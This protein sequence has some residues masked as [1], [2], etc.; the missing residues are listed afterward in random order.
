[1]YI[2]QKK[3]TIQDIFETQLLS[4]YKSYITLTVTDAN[5]FAMR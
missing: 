2:L 3:S 5:K 1:M 4:V